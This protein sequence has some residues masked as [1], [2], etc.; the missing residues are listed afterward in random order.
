[1]KAERWQKIEAIFHA[2][3]K[4]P[5]HE[6]TSYLDSECGDDQLVRSEV[7]SLLESVGDE[8][9]FLETPAFE[10]AA[11]LTAEDKAATIIGQTLGN[12]KVLELL[13]AGGMGETDFNSDQIFWF[14]YSRDHRQLALSRGTQTAD[15]VLIN[16]LK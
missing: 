12:Y 4:L 7:E 3:R 15:V 8:D 11:R 9:P 6:R 16:D 13:G 5:A 14:D 2:A 10:V 1:M